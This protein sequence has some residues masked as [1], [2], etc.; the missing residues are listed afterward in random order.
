MEYWEVDIRSRKD[1]NTIETIFS[2]EW[3]DEACDCLNR[4]YKEHP[5]VDIESDRES[6][7][8]GS[9]GVFADIYCTTNPRGVGIMD[10]FQK[11]LQKQME[12][13]QLNLHNE[14]KH[15]YSLMKRL[16]I[17]DASKL[18]ATLEFA[19]LFNKLKNE[20]IIQELKE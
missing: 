12:S 13:Y 5:E 7:V 11:Q 15:L 3:Y 14:I 4:W 10:D 8:D 9:D 1:G 19:K 16:D 17:N 2:G 20:G 6:L 18:E